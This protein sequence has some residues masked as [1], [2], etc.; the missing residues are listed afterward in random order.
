MS[1]SSFD[2]LSVLARY[3]SVVVVA[4]ASSSL[5]LTGA[6]KDQVRDDQARVESSKDG[7]SEE[8]GSQRAGTGN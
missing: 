7:Q 5:P 2:G 3:T 6:A 8:D 4:I 1:K